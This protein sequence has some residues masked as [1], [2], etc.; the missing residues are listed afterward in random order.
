ME[1]MTGYSFIES[2]TSQFSFSIELKTLNT[3]YL[4][5]FVNIPKI[6][7]HMEND[8]S[9]LIK[10]QISRGKAELNIEIYDWKESRNVDINKDVLKK[11]YEALKETEK[12][13]PGKEFS[14][15]SLLGLDGVVYRGRTQISDASL[16]EIEKTAAKAV[17]EAVRMRVKEGKALEKDIMK[18]LK[19]IS[20]TVVKIK[21]KSAGIAKDNYSKLKERIEEIAGRE[22]D[23]NRIYTEI[24]ILADKQDINEEITRLNDHIKKFKSIAKEKGQ[25][26]KQMDFIAQEMF[27]EINTIASKSNSSEISQHAVSVKN[28]IDKIREQSRN[29]V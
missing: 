12:I 19:I 28:A 11:Y 29:V 13:F 15:D 8:F 25:I 6:I 16:T 3:R 18:S 26:G 22:L 21:K 27:R 24:A 20:D 9:D 5:V 7:K 10:S 17:K 2:K 14:L 23:S 4:E 1:S